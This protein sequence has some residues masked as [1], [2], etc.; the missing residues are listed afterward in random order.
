MPMQARAEATRR[1]ILDAAITLFGERGYGETG[2]VDIVEAADLS[3][4]AFYYHF[5]SKE[6]VAAAI[7]DDYDRRL[8]ETVLA[9]VDP[10]APRVADMIRSTFA[11][12]ALQRW[13]ESIQVGQ[14]LM[15]A[16]EQISSGG[17][18][19]TID[20]TDKFV[21]MVAGAG[22]AGELVDGADPEEVGEAIWITVLGSHVLSGA[23][24][25]NPFARLARAWRFIL[26]T[27]TPPEALAGY[28]ELLDDLVA[29]YTQQLEAFEENRTLP[30]RAAASPEEDGRNGQ[31]SR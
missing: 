28:R 18:K 9:H 27:V 14:T 2:L 7:I 22:A 6:D 23:L 13:D 19:V 17:R 4:G 1:R 8:A 21:F 26:R 25:D 31:S 29:D 11:V 3:K 16:Y 30:T 12:Q 15:Q 24:H 10:T 5:T 20:W